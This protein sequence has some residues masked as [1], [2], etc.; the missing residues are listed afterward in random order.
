MRFEGGMSDNIVSAHELSK[1]YKVYARP[2]DRLIEGLLRIQ[3][4]I[5]GHRIAKRT[6]PGSSFAGLGVKVDD[7]LPVPHHAGYVQAP[8]D[9]EPER[10]HQKFTG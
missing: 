6:A 4:K 1:T 5:K 2:V 8:A 9:L 3:D 10:D 7:D